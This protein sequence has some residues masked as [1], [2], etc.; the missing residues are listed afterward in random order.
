LLCGVGHKDNEKT[1]RTT[2]NPHNPLVLVLRADI[3]FCR[4]RRTVTDPNKVAR[5]AFAK[6][7]LRQF[8]PWLRTMG[9]MI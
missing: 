5:S 9:T 7:G 6:R 2:C 4:L 1:A 3:L 8:P